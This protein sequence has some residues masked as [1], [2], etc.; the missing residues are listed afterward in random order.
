M[1]KT[2][3][4]F[5]VMTEKVVPFPVLTRSP[6]PDATSK[7]HDRMILRI[8]RQRLAFD[9]YSTVTELN[10]EP[11]LV[12]PFAKGSARKRHVRK[13][14]DDREEPP[15]TAPRVKTS[16]DNGQSVNWIAE[17]TSVR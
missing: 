16:F 11:A 4:K 14:T 6:L 15:A 3:N 12:V 1:S 5:S 2:P 17:G 10:P 7:R 8:G 13:K 9:F